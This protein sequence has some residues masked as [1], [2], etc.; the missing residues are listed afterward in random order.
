MIPET[1]A[2]EPPVAVDIGSTFGGFAPNLVWVIFF[3]AFLCFAV[4]TAILL[5]HWFKFATDSA[6]MW[7]VMM[8]Y[9]GGSAFLL[10][11]MFFSA[12]SIS[13]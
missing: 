10:L 11:F 1:V 2:I 12:V 13:L 6:I 5:Y 8:I 4:Y 3:I 7:P 9:L